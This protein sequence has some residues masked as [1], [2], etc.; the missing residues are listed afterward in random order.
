M[1]KRSVWFWLSILILALALL[2]PPGA[3]PWALAA[4]GLAVFILFVLGMI[5]TGVLVWTIAIAAHTGRRDQPTNLP[6]DKAPRAEVAETLNLPDWPE[7]I[8]TGDSPERE[9]QR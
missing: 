1:N 9:G 4:I 3:V 8:S 6:I 2:L 7:E 5:V